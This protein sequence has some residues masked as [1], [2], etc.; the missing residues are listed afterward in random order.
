MENILQTRY[1]AMSITNI[2]TFESIKGRVN[3]ECKDVYFVRAVGMN[4]TY[5]GDIEKMDESLLRQTNEGNSFYCRINMLP[6]LPVA[7]DIAFYVQSYTDWIASGKRELHIRTTRENVQLVHVLAKACEKVE[8]IYRSRNSKASESMLKNFI[9]KLLFWYDELFKAD[10]TGGAK[11]LW[12]EHKSIKI[13]AANVE[14]NQ[15]YLF[16]YMVTLTGCDVMLLQV[17]KDIDTE[18]EALGLSA[19]FVLGDFAEVSIPEYR[20]HETRQQVS[21][22]APAIVTGMTSTQSSMDSGTVTSMPRLVIPPRNRPSSARNVASSSNQANIA[23][24]VN[25]SNSMNTV[26][27][28]NSPNAMNSM[29]SESTVEKSFEELALLASSIVMIAIHDNKGEVI[30]SGSGIMV[31]RDGYILTNNH[32]TAGG[33]SYSVRIE[34]DNNVYETEEMIKYNQF[35]DLAII[36]INR[37][38]DPIKVYN[39]S[40]KLVRGQKVVAIGSPLGLFNS[41]SNGI[42]SGFR[43]IDMVDM[44]QFTAPTSHGS[45]GGA[46]LNMQGEV[47]GISTAG[48]SAGQ[49]INLAVGYEAINQFVKGFV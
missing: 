38:L 44:I 34:D 8:E 43:Q 31:G 5:L 46:V 35:L 17:N 25:T 12:N 6:K 29:N 18:D 2:S 45:S 47:I 16:Y 11:F 30:G 49:N 40:K 10:K 13:V 48:Y 4:T 19:K 1:N 15:E 24:V 3:G 42:I 39:G 36:R 20:W 9:V 26:N 28:V 21:I 41:V 33:R 22:P 27:R 7:E 14:K 23:N 32:V 37:R